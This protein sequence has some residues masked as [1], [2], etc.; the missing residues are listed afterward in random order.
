M[1]QYLN[2]IEMMGQVR[3]KTLC[4]L[5]LKWNQYLKQYLNKVEMVGQVRLKA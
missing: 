3:Y 1:K 5:N 2:R 4:H